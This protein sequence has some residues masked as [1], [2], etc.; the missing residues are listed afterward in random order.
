MPRLSTDT[1]A[2]AVTC[3]V[4]VTLLF[5]HSS[6]HVSTYEHRFILHAKV[7]TAV[8]PHLYTNGY[9]YNEVIFQLLL[10]C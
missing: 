8:S 10:I 6:L 7:L 5:M 2:A 1:F 9:V 3:L 4:N